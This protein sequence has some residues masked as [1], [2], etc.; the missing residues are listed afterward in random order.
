MAVTFRIYR[1][2][3]LSDTA[4]FRFQIKDDIKAAKIEATKEYR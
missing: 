4:L 2:Y 1:G 3:F